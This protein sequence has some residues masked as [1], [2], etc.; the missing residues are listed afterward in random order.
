[1]QDNS[2]IRV[3]NYEGG[4]KSLASSGI[5]WVRVGIYQVETD[6][7]RLYCVSYG[8]EEPRLLLSTWWRET[9]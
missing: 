9:Q 6:S 3:L 8:V 5:F 1:M 2:V 4:L 7:D